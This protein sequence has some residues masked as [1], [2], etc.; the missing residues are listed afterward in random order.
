M[1]DYVYG[2][3]EIVGKF[4]ADLIPHCRERGLPAASKT[5]GVIDG[6]GRLIAGLV[7]HGYQP[8]AGV[9]EISAAALPGKYWLTRETIRRMYQYPFL[10]C[11]CQMV[12]QRVAATDERQLRQLAAY[13]FAFIRIPRLLGRDQ[14]AVLCLLTYEDWAANK[15]N[16]RYK[17]HL[18]Q[19][20]EAA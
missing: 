8:E 10:Q 11:Q 2:Y 4:V 9:I 6:E 5:I 15:F 20:E 18:P 19:F 17:H 13:N 16:K 3:D 1:L 7:Y 12:V 14:D